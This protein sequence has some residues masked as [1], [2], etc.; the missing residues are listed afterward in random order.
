MLSIINPEKHE[1]LSRDFDEKCCFYRIYSQNATNSLYNLLQFFFFLDILLLIQ[2]DGHL[3]SESLPEY[4]TT[5]P[6]KQAVFSFVLMCFGCSLGVHSDEF[7][8]L[9]GILRQAPLCLLCYFLL[10]RSSYHHIFVCDN[11]RS[12]F[13]FLLEFKAVSIEIGDCRWLRAKLR[14]SLF[15]S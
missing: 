13:Y 3:S 1:K 14:S 10:L 4:G 11:S 2:P 7:W 12:V 6:Y 9:L 8:A 15:H 5:T